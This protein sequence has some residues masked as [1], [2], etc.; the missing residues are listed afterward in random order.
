MN[1]VLLVWLG[2]AIIATVTLT[3]LVVVLVL[4]RR[5]ID[6]PSLPPFTPPHEENRHE[7]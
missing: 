1:A 7:P 6:E 4:H 3:S 2:I 5:S